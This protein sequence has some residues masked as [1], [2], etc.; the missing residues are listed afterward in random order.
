MKGMC[1]CADGMGSGIMKKCAN[2][3]DVQMEWKRNKEKMGKR[4]MGKRLMG[5]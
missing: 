4:L 3:G 2:E 5:R 1:R